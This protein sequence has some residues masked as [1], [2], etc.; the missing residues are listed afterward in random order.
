MNKKN[1]QKK[2]FFII[3]EFILTAGILTSFILLWGAFI[4]KP[5]AEL[6]E[7]KKSKKTTEVETDKTPEEK[8]R[9][10]KLHIVLPDKKSPHDSTLRRQGKDFYN[11]NF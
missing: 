6:S 7:L 8:P 10:Q 2:I 5:S 4:I 9:F 3:F 1:P 11:L